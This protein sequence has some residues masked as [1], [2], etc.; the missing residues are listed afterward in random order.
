MPAYSPS[1]KKLMLTKVLASD[2]EFG[3]IQYTVIAVPEKG[4]HYLAL[5]DE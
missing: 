3:T 4:F 2:I 5:E 1:R